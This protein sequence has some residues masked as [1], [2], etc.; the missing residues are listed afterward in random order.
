MT[1]PARDRGQLVLLAAAVL[2]VAL[3]PVVVAVL[4]F[5]YHPD[6]RATRDY[7][8]AGRSAERVLIEAVNDVAGT[9]TDY[10]WPRRRVAVTEVRRRLR[11][12]LASLASGRVESGTAVS[13]A[14]NSSAAAAWAR[15]HCPG[16][17]DREFGP[18]AVDRGLVVQ[19][20]AGETHLLAAAF[21]VRVTTRRGRTR[22]TVTVLAVGGV[23]R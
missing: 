14:Y 17:P 12:R 15:R 11:P 21:D 23:A 16:G 7:A 3:T 8:D 4:Q 6:V 20:R 22:F 10:E 13:V 2:A 1:R 5:G 18:C 9:A 19:S